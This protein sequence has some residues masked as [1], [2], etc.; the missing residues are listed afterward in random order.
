MDRPK[1]S[2]NKKQ[3]IAYPRKCNFC[4]YISNN[5]TMYHFHNKAHQPIPKDTVCHFGCGMAA[6]HCNTGG[7]FTCSTEYHKCP[8]YLE[9]LSERTKK[10]W[11]GATDRKLATKKI[12]EQRVVYNKESRKKNIDSIKAKAILLPNDAKDY[13]SYARKCRKIAQQWAKSEGY[14]IGQQTYHVDHKLSL[15]DCYYAGLSVEVASHPKNLQVI[16]A[17]EN[18]AKGR[19]SCITVDDLY[20]K[21]NVAF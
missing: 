19:N 16:P 18:V 2:L 7:K 9:Q 5:P 3:K 20:E 6:T 12:F 1:G 14:E 15:L 4:D 21:I 17:N 8:A 13:R 11:D 10:S